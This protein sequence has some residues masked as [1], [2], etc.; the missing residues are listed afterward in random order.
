[1]TRCPACSN[2]AAEMTRCP[3]GIRVCPTMCMCRVC[4][5]SLGVVSFCRCFVGCFRIA[6]IELRYASQHNRTCVFQQKTVRKRARF[7]RQPRCVP[8][9]RR[10]GAR[11]NVHTMPKRQGL[12]TGL[13]LELIA[14]RLTLYWKTASLAAAS[15]P[16]CCKVESV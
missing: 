4:V 15:R 6:E 9:M 8:H 16:R 13:T 1:M 2:R 5:P 7:L 12:V 11:Q 14:P 10:I 3:Q